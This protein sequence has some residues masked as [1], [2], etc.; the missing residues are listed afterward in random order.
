MPGPAPFGLSTIVLFALAGLFAVVAYL[1]VAHLK[2]PGRPSL[3]AK[4][5]PSPLWFILPR[6]IPAVIL[7]G[8]LQVLDNE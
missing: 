7:T 3:G 2:D 4:T 6:L 8:M 1:V 5:G